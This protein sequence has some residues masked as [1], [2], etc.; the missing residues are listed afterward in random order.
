MSLNNVSLV[1]LAGLAL[2]VT[3]IAA[4]ASCMSDG[5]RAR[6]AAE[7]KHDLETTAK[8]FAAKIPGTTG[9]VSCVLSDSDQDGYVSC[10]V[11]MKSE[12]P[13][14]I[15]C[16]SPYATRWHKSAG[17]KINT[18]HLRAPLVPAGPAER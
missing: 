10:T 9:D 1:A 17:C 8:K 15:E 12:K 14:A 6:R 4:A 13:I 3:Y 11:F 16:M 5:E 2:C 18:K 7:R